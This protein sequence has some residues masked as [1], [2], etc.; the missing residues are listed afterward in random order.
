MIV[1]GLGYENL[2]IDIFDYLL[3]YGNVKKNKVWIGNFLWVGWLIC[4]IE[5][6]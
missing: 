6:K 4:D 5:E 3:V 2:K 1:N